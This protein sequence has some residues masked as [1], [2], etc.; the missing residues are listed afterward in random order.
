MREKYDDI[1]KMTVL[2]EEALKLLEKGVKQI[3]E[4]E[5]LV[6]KQTG[7]ANEET[8]ETLAELERVKFEHDT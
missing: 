8:T 4:E 5:K 7:G 3:S 2:K 6:E 1:H